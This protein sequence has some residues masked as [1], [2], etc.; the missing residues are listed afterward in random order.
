MDNILERILKVLEEKNGGI[1]LWFG[2]PPV[3]H[4]N[5]PAQQR[6]EPEPKVDEEYGQ[7]Q[8][9]RVVAYITANPGH[10]RDQII[11]NTNLPSSVVRQI[12]SYLITKGIAEEYALRREP[13]ARGPALKGIRIVGV[14]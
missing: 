3:I 5:Y 7:E 8:Y 12:I 9:E 6:K 10:F 2:R 13:S 4:H 14:V 11:Q 1:I